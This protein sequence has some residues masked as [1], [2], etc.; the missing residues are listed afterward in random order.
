MFQSTPDG[1]YL[2]VNQ[3]MAVMHGYTSPQAMVDATTDIANQEYE[4]PAQRDEFMHLLEE[5]KVGNA[6]PWKCRDGRHPTRQ[7]STLA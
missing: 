2:R 7:S 6:F 1:R 4:H 5:K 3:A